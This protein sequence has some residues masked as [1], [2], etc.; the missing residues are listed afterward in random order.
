MERMYL[1]GDTFYVKEILKSKYGARWDK[2]KSKWYVTS[3]ATRAAAQGFIDGQKDEIDK[4]RKEEDEERE[5]LRAE[6]KFFE[7]EAQKQ[8]E[9][10][11]L[12]QQAIDAKARTERQ[13]KLANIA[14]PSSEEQRWIAGKLQEKRSG[15]VMLAV[16]VHRYDDLHEKYEEWFEIMQHPQRL[17]G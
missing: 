6:I 12:R 14:A 16:D 15:R 10:A 17:R 4:R 9:L 1:E 8:Q 3:E 7:E 11:R 5:A 2:D 13:T